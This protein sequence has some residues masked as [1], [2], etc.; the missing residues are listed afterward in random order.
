MQRDTNLDFSDLTVA[1]WSL[2]DYWSWFVE[3]KHPKLSSM[4]CHILLKN[5]LLLVGSPSGLTI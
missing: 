4:E 3:P 5:L 1:A 2:V